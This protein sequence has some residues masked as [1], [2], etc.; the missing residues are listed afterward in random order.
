MDVL[1]II[2]VTTILYALNEYNGNT[3]Y[4][5]ENSN[6]YVIVLLIHYIEYI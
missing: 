5:I 2:Y 3:L 6:Y 4:N 1:Y